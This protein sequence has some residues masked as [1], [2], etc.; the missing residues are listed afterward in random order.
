MAARRRMLFNGLVVASVAVDRHGVVLG[1]PRITAPGLFDTD[2]DEL[3]RVANDLQDILEDLP[4]ALRRD[5]ASCVEAA[6]AALRRALGRRIGK[7]PMV[8]IHLIRV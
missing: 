5:D 7:R 4:A 3:A 1:R 6:K 8:D 2:D